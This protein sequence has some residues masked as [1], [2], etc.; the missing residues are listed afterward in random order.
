MSVSSLRLT[1]LLFAFLWA[2]LCCCHAWA[3]LNTAAGN[4]ETAGAVSCCGG[5]DSEPRP[6]LPQPCDDHHHCAA[7]QSPLGWLPEVKLAA[8][9]GDLLGDSLPPVVFIEPL[10]R[11][12][13]HLKAAAEGWESADPPTLLR[14]RCALTI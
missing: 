12:D 8:A 5:C 4:T 7:C 14:L 13:Q 1:L 10:P 9:H 2:Q 11:H 3:L 6:E